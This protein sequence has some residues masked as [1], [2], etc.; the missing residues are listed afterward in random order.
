MT[1]SLLKQMKHILVDTLRRLK[2]ELFMPFIPPPGQNIRLTYGYK[3][4]LTAC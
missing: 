2:F 4:F 1:L 3:L